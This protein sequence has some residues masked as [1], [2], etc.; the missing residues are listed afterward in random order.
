[1]ASM[2]FITG[3]S[4]GLGR[5]VAV[6]AL[7]AGHRVV[8]TVRN[9][10]DLA[11][12]EALAPGRAVGFMLEIS[13]H[14]A[15]PAAIDRVEREIGP[16][17]VVVNNAGYG[18][19]GPLESIPIADFRKLYDVNL[20]GA[21]AVC[22]AV[23]PH[24]RGRGRGRIINISSATTFKAAPALGAYSSSKAAMNCL[25]EV[26]AKEVG[27]FGIKVTNVIPASFRTD[28]AGRSLI[29][30]GDTV[31]D[32]AHLDAQRAAR[33]SRNGT[34]PGDPTKFAAAVLDI[35]SREEPPLN[36]LMGPNA[37]RGCGE[38]IAAMQKDIEESRDLALASDFDG[39]PAT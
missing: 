34:Q 21:L 36:L 37:L 29:R 16:I 26:L 9:A 30:S 6:A 31:D 13:D 15:I 8:G 25:S 28:W 19:E 2:W 11:A 27:P 14:D 1:M 33:A 4:T 18:Q 24:M 20:F 5:A 7:N 35:A 32:Y 12:F 22:Q 39:V 10:A 23:L 3:V 17:E 38:R